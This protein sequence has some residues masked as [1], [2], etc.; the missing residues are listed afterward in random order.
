ML[1]SNEREI[2]GSYKML[3]T[4][5]ADAIYSQKS[6]LLKAAKF[7]KLVGWFCIILGLPMLFMLVPGIIMIGLGVFLLVR[8]NKNIKVIE[9]ATEAYCAE[10][11]VA[12]V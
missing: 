7:L 5:D 4:K 2:I 6:M 10:I 9:Q 3:P 1:F 11:G 12:P 8:A